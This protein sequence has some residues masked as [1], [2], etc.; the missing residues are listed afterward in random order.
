M[1]GWG[2]KKELPKVQ[3]SLKGIKEKSKVLFIDDE[4]VDLI[5]LLQAEGWH[6]EQWK[7][8]N[9][10]TELES[11][12]YDLIFLD[13]G[14]VGRKFS[15]EEEGFRI[16]KR[17]KSINPSVLIVSYSGQ[18]FDSTKSE[19]WALADGN[20]SKS[21]GAIKAIELLEDLL[22][23]KFTSTYLWNEALEILKGHGMSET[24]IEKVKQ[25]IIKK[26]EP[27]KIE[28]K[29]KSLFGTESSF[30][31]V[32]GTISKIVMILKYMNGSGS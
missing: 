10:L 30:Q 31:I 16:L 20:L 18:R 6:V 5:P 7:D 26:E 19:F 8:V 22:K 13:I 32:L 4:E 21:S 12:K 3:L 29:I 28:E 25:N 9:S 17:I 27:K 23:Q 11:G 1:F 24:D 14:G 15:P 2:Q